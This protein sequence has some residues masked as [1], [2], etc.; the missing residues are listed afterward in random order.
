MS[1]AGMIKIHRHAEPSR[2]TRL[3]PRCF[4][5]MLAFSLLTTIPAQAE[6]A[7]RDKPVNLEADRVTVDETKQNATFDG[8]VVLTQGTLTIRGDRM[9]VQQ[10]ADGFKTG[11]A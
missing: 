5:L 3:A 6:H 7:D 11:T 8:N 10:D 1:E 4:V 2:A 9:I